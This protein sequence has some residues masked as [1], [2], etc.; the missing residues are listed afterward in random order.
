MKRF[1]VSVAALDMAPCGYDNMLIDTETAEMAKSIALNTVSE[2]MR[3]PKEAFIVQ[4]VEA[5]P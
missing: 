3:S 1:Y 4:V 5:H 2:A